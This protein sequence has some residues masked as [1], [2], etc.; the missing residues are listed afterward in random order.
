VYSMLF[1]TSLNRAVI[2]ASLNPTVIQT[3]FIH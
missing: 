2:P 3:V 1:T